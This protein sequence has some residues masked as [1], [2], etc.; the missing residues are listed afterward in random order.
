LDKKKQYEQSKLHAA[1]VGLVIRENGI[2]T[3]A[4]FTSAPP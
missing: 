2:L 3:A 4:E 1:P